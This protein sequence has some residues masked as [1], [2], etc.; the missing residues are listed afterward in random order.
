MVKII[1]NNDLSEAKK[2]KLALLDFSATWCGPCSMLAPVLQELSEEL[3]GEVGV[4]SIDV[5]QNPSLAIDYKIMNI[6]AL[7]LL[8]DGEKVGMTVGFQPKA[9]LEKFIEEHK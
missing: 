7:V 3:A 1:S 8:K 4:Y 6:P 9:S 5:D 2:E